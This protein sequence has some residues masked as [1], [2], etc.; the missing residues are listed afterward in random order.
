[1]KISTILL[2]AA[3]LISPAIASVPVITPDADTYCYDNRWAVNALSPH[4]ADVTRS[5]CNDNRGKTVKSFHSVKKTVEY[6]GA[7]TGRPFKVDFRFTRMGRNAGKLDSDQCVRL[8]D[9]LLSRCPN[10][11]GGNLAS[12]KGGA[13]R[14]KGG[15]EWSA[16]IDCNTEFCPR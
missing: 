6:R 2:A 7:G 14:I 1:M 3:A 11:V 8:F 9:N 12:F 10:A 15:Q 4:I 5:L 16:V 13:S